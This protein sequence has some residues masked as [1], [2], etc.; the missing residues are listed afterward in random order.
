MPTASEALN[1]NYI[2]INKNELFFLH[3][4][5]IRSKLI[6]IAI[7]QTI[8]EMNGTLTKHE[9]ETLNTFRQ[10]LGKCLIGSGVD[11][12]SIMEDLVRGIIFPCLRSTVVSKFSESK[13]SS[14]KKVSK[15]AI[16][17]YWSWIKAAQY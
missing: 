14:L 7:N 12:E 8:A 3:D 6:Q 9:K 13:D 10:T 16:E 15:F 4:K 1:R 17:N 11:L 2:K 5:K